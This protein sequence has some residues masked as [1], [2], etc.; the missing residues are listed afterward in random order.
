MLPTAEQR[1]ASDDVTIQHHLYSGFMHV[2]ADG[3]YMS[4]I[5]ILMQ[6][7]AEQRKASGMMAHFPDTLPRHIYSV[8]C[9]QVDTCLTCS[10]RLSSGKRQMKR[11]TG[12]W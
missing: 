9:M 2:Y 7:T 8:H 6:P 11:S 3:Y 5:P 1:K 4:D 12:A 10:L